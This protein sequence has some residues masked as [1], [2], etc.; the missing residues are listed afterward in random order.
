MRLDLCKR[1][2]DLCTDLEDSFF[3]IQR[4]EWDMLQHISLVGEKLQTSGDD[5]G[6]IALVSE[7]R[8]NHA[9]VGPLLL[10]NIREMC[11]S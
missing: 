1:P 6:D 9:I 3:G 5:S 11:L 10:A 2:E 8:L 4:R 7:G